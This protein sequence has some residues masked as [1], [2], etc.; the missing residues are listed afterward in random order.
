MQLHPYPQK[1]RGVNVPQDNPQAGF[2]GRRW[3]NAPAFYPLGGQFFK[4]F[5]LLY[6]SQEFV[7][8][9]LKRT[10]LN[11]LLLLLALCSL[12]PHIN[13]LR[14][15]PKQ[16]IFIQIF[17]LELSFMRIQ[18]K[19]ARDTMGPVCEGSYRPHSAFWTFSYWTGRG[20]ENFEQKHHKIRWPFRLYTW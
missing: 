4:V 3:I 11:W 16:T 7:I 9:I 6:T 17:V 8:M 14:S 19:A 15:T 5:W 1:C 20:S 12:L 10:L 18:T 13:F 2:D